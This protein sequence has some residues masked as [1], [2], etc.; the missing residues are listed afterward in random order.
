MDR[1]KL[2]WVSA[3]EGQLFANLVKE[4][5]GVMQAMGPFDLEEYK[6]PL[7]AVEGFSIHLAC[8]GSWAWKATKIKTSTT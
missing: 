4:L 1:V 7:A 2:R 8:G 6:L 3:A 5:S